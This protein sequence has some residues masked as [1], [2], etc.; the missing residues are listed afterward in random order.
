MTILLVRW[1]RFF[2]ITIA[3]FARFLHTPPATPRNTAT[4]SLTQNQVPQGV[5]V[6]VR[7]GPPEIETAEICGFF[8]T[9]FVVC[10]LV[11]LPPCRFLGGFYARFLHGFC[12]VV[13]AIKNTPPGVRRGY[14]SD[15]CPNCYALNSR[16]GRLHVSQCSHGM[17]VGYSLLFCSKFNLSNSGSAISCSR[18]RLYAATLPVRL[19]DH[20]N[21]SRRT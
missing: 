18:R 20:C 9:C 17:P 14:Y 2:P 19:P 5:S 21:S 13:W 1:G 12:T 6:Q 3:S 8:F 15:R 7:S 10:V 11:Q 4:L 16:F